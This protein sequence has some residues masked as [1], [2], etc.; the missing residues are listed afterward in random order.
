VVPPHYVSDM[1]INDTCVHDFDVGRWLLDTEITRA[2]DS[3]FTD[4][5]A[6]VTAGRSNGPSSWDGYAAQ[7]VCDAGLEALKSGAR[8]EVSLREQPDLY[9]ATVGIGP[10]GTD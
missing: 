10:T 9:N 1:I 3:E 5:I 6:A 4:W 8:V 2:Y 7:V